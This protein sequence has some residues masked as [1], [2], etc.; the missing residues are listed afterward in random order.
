[1]V[2]PIDRLT[3]YAFSQTELRK[4]GPCGGSLRRTAG[5]L[6]P[7]S[8]TDRLSTLYQDLQRLNPCQHLSAGV[9]I[10]QLVPRGFKSSSARRSLQAPKTPI[11]A[12]DRPV[13]LGLVGLGL[14]Q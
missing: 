7:A 2:H 14:V 9:V 3:G 6:Y 4:S 11:I 5:S 1:M 13:S 12:S 8:L 10:S